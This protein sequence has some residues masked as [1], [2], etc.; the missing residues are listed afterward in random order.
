MRGWWATVPWATTLALAFGHL[1]CGSE[2]SPGAS[3]CSAPA[4]VAPNVAATA[5]DVQAILTRSCALGGCHLSAPG[6]GGLVLDARW[7][8]AMVGVP[9]TQNPAMP[10]VTAGDPRRSWL[11]TK[12]RRPFCSTGCAQGCGGAMPP[13]EAVSPAELAVI[14]GWIEGG[15][16]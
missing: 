9:S 4:D 16:R 8:A 5:A 10:L 3:T 13:G 6:A 14:V 12:L 7:R 1:G 2:A 11:V 15:A